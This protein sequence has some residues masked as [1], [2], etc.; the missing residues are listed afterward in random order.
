MFVSPSAWAECTPAKL[1]SSEITPS[2]DQGNF[3]VWIGYADTNELSWQWNNGANNNAELYMG[4]RP[5]RYPI[6]LTAACLTGTPELKVHLRAGFDPGECDQSYVFPITPPEPVIEID[7]TPTDQS[8][9]VINVAVAY[10]AKYP[11]F[12][13]LKIWHAR[14]GQAP[15]LIWERPDAYG[16][17]VPGSPFDIGVTSGVGKLIAE[18]TACSTREYA[19]ID[20]YPRCDKCPPSEEVGDPV[21]VANG[22]MTF[23][24]TDPLPGTDFFSLT[25]R[26]D[27]RAV[28]YRDHGYFGHLFRSP[29]DAQLHVFTPGDEIVVVNAAADHYS[30]RRVGA[31]YVNLDRDSEVTLRDGLNGSRIL[32]DDRLEREY[33]SNG[34]IVAYRDAATTR[35]V[36]ITYDANANP[37]RVHDSWGNWAWAL[38]DPVTRLVQSIAVEGSPT[39]VSYQYTAGKQPHTVS[40]AEGVFRTYEYLG[41]WGRGYGIVT[42]VRN[43]AGHLLESHTYD[44]N[45]RALTS[46]GPSGDI[47][48]I[49]FNLA[50]REPGE[51]LTRVV[52]KSGRTE[53]RYL[54]AVNGQWRTVE[55]VN[56][57]ST[58]SGGGEVFAHDAA[59]N[60]VRQQNAAG[61]IDESLY[62]SA[63]RLTSKRTALTPGTCDP[64]TAVDRCRQTPASLPSVDL[65]PTIA[66]LTTRFEYGDANGPLQA[67]LIAT[68]SLIDPGVERQE[69]FTFEAATGRVLTSAVAGLAAAGTSQTRLTTTAYYDGVEGAAFAPGG[70]FDSAWLALPQPKFVA[71]VDGPRLDVGD[72]TTLVYYPVDASV[73]ARLR[74]RLAAQRNA[75]GHVTRFEA[76]DE[77]GNVTRVVDPN[78]VV[79]EAAFDTMGRPTATTVKGM[80]GCDTTADPLCSTDVTTARSYLGAGSLAEEERAA[81][82]TSYEYDTRDRIAA[83]SR[84]PAPTDLRERITYTYDPVSGQRDSERT[85]AREAG[86]WVEKR[87][88]LS[89]H[90]SEGRLIRQTHGDNSAILYGY[91]GAG[92]L[93]SIQDENHSAPNTTYDYDAGGRLAA[94]TQTLTSAPSGVTTSYTYDAHG[95][96]ASVTD[97]NG[98]LT[99]YVYNDF[100]EM[101]RQV[102]PVTGTTTYVYD[103]SG[104]LVSTTDANGAMN[105]RTYDALNRPLSSVASRSGVPAESV[106]WTYDAGALGVGRLSTMTDPT[107][108]A[109]FQYDRRGLLTSEA[110]TIE[111]TTY[112]TTYR[113]DAGARRSSIGYPSGNVVS[114]TYDHADRPITAS[115]GS[116]ALVSSAKYLP[117]G[118]ATEVTYGNGT[119]RSVAYDARYRISTNAI[120]G[121]LGT[122]ASYAYAHDPVGNITSISD[123]L[124]ATY[125]RTFAYDDLHRLTGGTTGTS[126]WGT[127]SYGYDSMGNLLQSTLG[128]ETRTFTY[129]GTT[130]KLATVAE[131]GTSRAVAYDLAGN[132]EHVGAQAYSY[133]PRNHLTAADVLRYAYDG[134]GVRAITA[135]TTTRSA[136]T[137]ASLALDQSSVDGETPVI[138]TIMLTAPAPPGGTTVDL[139]TTDASAATAP[140]TVTVPEGASSTTFTVTTHRP[141]AT[142]PAQ[143]T[144]AHE[145]VASTVTLEVVR[146]PRLASLSVPSSRIGG[147]TSSG[148][149]TIDTPASVGGTTV[150]LASSHPAVTV[151]GT[152]MIEAGAATA[153]FTLTASAEAEDV[154]AVVTATLFYSQMATMTVY[155]PGIE[156]AAISLT[157]RSVVGGV[158]NSTGTVTLTAPAR[159]G[160]A[161]T[162]LTSS[163]TGVVSVPTNVTVPEGAT[164][165][166]FAATTASTGAPTPVTIAATYGT[167]MAETLTVSPCGSWTADAAQ[168]QTD[169]VWFDDAVPGG[170][171]TIPAPWLWDTSEKAS[172]TQSHTVAPGSGI[173]EW[174]FGGTAPSDTVSGITA[175][176][177]IVTYVLLDP[178]NP[179]RQI[180]L[181]WNVNYGNW[182]ERAAYWGENLINVGTDGTNSRWRVG[183]LPPLGQW[184]RLEVPAGAVGLIDTTI[185]AMKFRVYD[186]RAWFDRTGRTTC[187]MPAP[188]PPEIPATD[189][190]WVDDAI[191]AG[192]SVHATWPGG[193]WIWDTAQK[194][195]GTQSSTDPRNNVGHYHRFEGATTPFP[196]ETGD[197][198][199]AYVLLDP[200]DPPGEVML[201]F[202]EGTS[203]EHRAYWG[204]DL[205]AVG[206]NDTESRRRMGDLPPVGEWVRLEVPA[207]AVGLEGRSINGIGFWLHGGRG[208]FDWAGKAPASA[209]AGAG[210]PQRSAAACATRDDGKMWQPMGWGRASRPD[211]QE[212]VPVSLGVTT[213]L[214]A[215]TNATIETRRYSLYTPELQL[216]AETNT[217]ALAPWIAHEYIWFGGE[218]LAQVEVAS[219]KIAYYFNDHLGAPILQTDAAGAVV[220]RVERDPYGE[221]YATRVGSERHQPLGLPGQ[222]YDASSDRQYNIFRWYRAGWGRYTQSDP[223]LGMLQSNVAARRSSRYA[224]F[225]ADPYRYA[226]G[227]PTRFVDPLGLAPCG[228]NP[229]NSDL[230]CGA[231]C[232]AG[233]DWAL[234][235]FRSYSQ[236]I[237]NLDLIGAGIGVV[238]GLMSKNPVVGACGAIG[239]YAVGRMMGS[240]LPGWFEQRVEDQYRRCLEQCKAM[241]CYEQ[242][243]DDAPCRT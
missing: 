110:K 10:T 140:G 107:G 51:R 118:P 44:S 138:A 49:E 192:A 227:S 164:S 181:E 223:L 72:L 117:F 165:E 135:Q 41:V 221:R 209:M 139:M 158:M 111:G 35:M 113:Y 23:T 121:P 219:G 235:S 179:P 33:D 218:P 187:T 186:G 112:P 8:N 134:R 127:T 53:S 92:R 84:G 146:D 216:L 60:V 73:P 217:S 63:G 163:D 58:C 88:E 173:R 65:T 156:L 77:F 234:C 116:T 184:V 102:S 190:V 50:G 230:P 20:L 129:A 66:T 141:A 205:L 27:S 71:R 145:D 26:F 152:V 106:S 174:Y 32:V 122:I 28:D 31:S 128:A 155:A 69:Q 206:T 166:T 21:A 82:V 6:H 169:T 114:Y 131:N 91:D 34:R 170:A 5:N 74:G 55:I 202:R 224:A 46:V 240:R 203:W 241:A 12:G 78:G 225:T 29:L 211:E 239:L 86:A 45:Q 61:Y 171:W 133:G 215:Q 242:D 16:N 204:Y 124:D 150:A 196:I 93:A 56:G 160:G 1:T 39:T 105:T 199:V 22:N 195:A 236:I 178:C 40:T 185:N 30:F 232:L 149:A 101:I 96:L 125:N 48:L 229:A 67:T 24:D 52:W 126:L 89:L 108:S 132:E 238:G 120:N 100:G 19:E 98:N 194:A 4:G 153:S 162:T 36:H 214:V 2:D 85:F 70:P 208:W 154:V 97:P 210:G 233:R 59:G 119:V 167:T 83:I 11:G 151:P 115:V 54:R 177:V 42:A 161:T 9:N 213:N 17:G 25:R 94:V 168:L 109:A 201:A 18:G 130:P 231:K 180:M 193:S 176:D 157:P 103:A 143:I 3:T 237:D 222:E 15:A 43:G 243:P 75:A 99:S 57:C 188:A 62:D 226:D 90:D 136:S 220:W 197:T 76:Y 13:R 198:L 123:N 142:T 14:P 159:A 104:N 175:N 81:G 37:V 87:V 7:L 172:G 200:C 183:D 38:T 68:A 80:P 148:S 212:V 47:D 189:V 64:A 191:P 144:A 207:A 137:L 182:G 147:G 95:N 228:P 79:T